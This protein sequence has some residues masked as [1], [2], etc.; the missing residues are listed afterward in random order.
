MPR[1]MHFH[2]SYDVVLLVLF[3]SQGV[4]AGYHLPGSSKH[5][6]FRIRASAAVSLGGC[7]TA[8]EPHRYFLTAVLI[9][10]MQIVI[11]LVGQSNGK[12]YRDTFNDKD[13]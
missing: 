11:L 4:R 2:S 7:I 12:L 6:I 8:S 3:L 9:G 10:H 5:R 1:S 13:S